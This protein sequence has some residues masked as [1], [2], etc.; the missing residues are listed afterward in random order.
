ML[1]KNIIGANRKENSNFVEVDG[2]VFFSRYDKVREK[3]K[4]KQKEYNKFLDYKGK[5]LFV[6]RKEHTVDQLK[7][8]ARYA[9]E[10]NVTGK[11]IEIDKGQMFIIGDYVSKVKGDK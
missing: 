7:A 6:S 9:S 11:V 1:H 5:N 10:I 2:T 4:V 8:Y 3:R